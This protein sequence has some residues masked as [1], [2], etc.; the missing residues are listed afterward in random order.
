MPQKI[1]TTAFIILLACSLRAQQL[2]H[3]WL[4]PVGAEKTLVF[5]HGGPGYNSANFEFDMAPRLA[6]MGY[7]VL[8]YDQRGS[9][10]SEGM[11][12]EFTYPEAVADLHGLLTAKGVKKAYLLGHSFGGTVAVKF[13]DA[14]ADM[15]A[16][17][18][19]ISAPMD[20]PACF[21]AIQANCLEAMD[22]KEDTIGP[23]SIKALAAMD[24][25]TLE[26]SGTNFM[27]AMSN[28]LYSPSEDFKSGRKVKAKLARDPLGKWAKK[29]SFAPVKG[30]FEKEHYIMGN[31]FSLLAEVSKTVP[32]YAILGD[33]D[34]LFDE[35][36]IKKFQEVLENDVYVLS[37]ASHAVFLDDPYGFLDAL[38]EI[39]S[40]Q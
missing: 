36:A 6:K 18:V 7:Q 20:F 2:Y 29:S 25:T 9:G 34:G 12:G 30:F 38:G 10:R 40:R 5:L 35:A 8:V 16:A 19:L 21:R 39:L 27:Y 32:C 13:A 37:L 26:Y 11:T 1:L 33:E 14:H 23:K 24:T 4:G 28:G 15:V 22:I 31:H 17:V 3:K